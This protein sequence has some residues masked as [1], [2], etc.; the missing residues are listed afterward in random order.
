MRL[1]YY[2]WGTLLF[3]GAVL[4]TYNRRPTTITHQEASTYGTLRGQ[5][6]GATAVSQYREA[7]V[8]DALQGARVSP[9]FA[10]AYVKKEWVR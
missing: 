9:E 6:T 8:R 5:A 4:A 1:R 7:R 3:Y 2:L 10:Q